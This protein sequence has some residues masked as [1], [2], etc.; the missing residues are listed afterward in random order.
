MGYEPFNP[1][2]FC[3]D[4]MPSDFYSQLHYEKSMP[5]CSLRQMGR[6]MGFD[7]TYIDALCEA[8]DYSGPDPYLR[9]LSR[10]LPRDMKHTRLLNE[11]YIAEMF[12]CPDSKECKAAEEDFDTA[13]KGI[14]EMVTNFIAYRQRQMR[15]REAPA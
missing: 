10:A 5:P 11:M 9:Y 13:F 3:E 1:L 14:F 12:W 4:D 6:G 15:Y 2:A 7:N 8:A